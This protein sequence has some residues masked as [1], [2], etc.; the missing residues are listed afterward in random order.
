MR[1]ARN[2]RGT[3]LIVLA[4]ALVAAAGLFMLV[5]QY[6]IER[7]NARARLIERGQTILDALAAGIRA[8]TR[9]G[10]Y[11]DDRLEAIFEELAHATGIVGL[12][13]AGPDG[14]E[15]AVGGDP[16]RVPG[17]RPGPP[18]W[19]GDILA[20]AAEAQF[21]QAGMG[22]GPGRGMGRGLGPGGGGRGAPMLPGEDEGRPW[23]PGMYVLTVALDSSPVAEE[24]RSAAL[25][26][27]ASALVWLAAVGSV[28]ATVLALSRQRRLRTELL[29]SRE[30]AAHSEK[31]AHIGAGL[32]HET[33][34]PLGV[35]RGLAQAIAESSGND[36]GAR[37]MARDIVDEVDRAVGQINSFLGLARPVEPEPRPVALDAFLG[38]LLPLLQAEARGSNVSFHCETNGLT[39]LADED[40]L[41]RAL[42]NLAINA[43]RACDA[44]GYVR[45]SAE[46]DGGTV[47]LTVADNGCGIAPE[48]LPRVTEP[49]FGRF[50]GG[51]GLGLSIV[52]HI[53][54][55]HG[56]RLLI[57]SEPGTGTRVSLADMVEVR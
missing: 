5:R 19:T 38:R 30:R 40:L 3:Y 52:E 25:R 57:R 18:V 16:V 7:T 26:G 42:L 39:V 35:V 34:N 10:R 15:V 22:R 43:V 17:V 20:I 1:I 45:L 2:H 51:S 12:R 27:L 50:Q 31:M 37:G 56:W 14:G 9:M 49:Y 8:Q 32:A 44:A 29:L 24:I 48:D 47:T 6:R 41:R 54:R 46:R 23:G 53:A 11:R 21:A 28:A 4:A 13:L 55:A 36:A 33:K